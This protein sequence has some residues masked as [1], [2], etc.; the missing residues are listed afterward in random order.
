M[1]WFFNYKQK[2]TKKAIKLN[3]DRKY[4]LKQLIMPISA[5]HKEA[6]NIFNLYDKIS[7]NLINRSHNLITLQNM[8]YRQVEL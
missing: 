4:K 1:K 5:G 8:T 6:I 7:P 2:F 3:F